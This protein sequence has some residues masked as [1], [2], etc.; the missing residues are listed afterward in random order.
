MPQEMNYKII[1][2]ESELDSFI[3]YL[4]DLEDNEV[5]YLCLFGRHKYDPSFPTSKDSGQLNRVIARNKRELKEKIRRMEC[6]IGSY[7][8]D[9]IM[10]SQECLALYLAPNPRSL[11][12]ANKGLIVELA[13]RFANGELEFN[14]I[15]L[16]TTEVHK[17]VGRK[18]FV[19]FDFDNVEFKDYKEKIKEILP[20]PSMYLV[21]ETRG[22]FHLLVILEKIKNLKNS[23]Y[24]VIAKLSAC[25][26]RGSEMLVPVPGTIQGGFT[27]R[28][29]SI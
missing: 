21:I 16:A 27:P 25:D 5:F 1:T 22:G 12:K 3:S 26:V 2:D 29:L 17:A 28:V 6:P 10:A 13:T 8:R 15:S 24:P 4:P 23:W 9:G 11:L 20:D 18:F 14:P 7:S 19:D